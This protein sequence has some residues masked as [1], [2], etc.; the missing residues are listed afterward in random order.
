MDLTLGRENTA[1]GL[2]GMDIFVGFKLEMVPGEHDR[3]SLI[4][5]V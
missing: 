1:L 4:Q 2:S 5:S 3:K